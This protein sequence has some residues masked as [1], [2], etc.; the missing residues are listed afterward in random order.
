M[1]EEQCDE[2]SRSFPECNGDPMVK[3]CVLFTPH[4]RPDI[5]F[6]DSRYE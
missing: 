1:A 3:D 5:S 6:N 2:C 4:T